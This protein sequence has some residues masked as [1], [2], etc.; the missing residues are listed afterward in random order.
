MNGE[1]SLDD[2]ICN[3]EGLRLY[4]YFTVTFYLNVVGG[5]I[6]HSAPLSDSD[7]RVSYSPAGV[8]LPRPT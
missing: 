2:L 5:W 6:G 8:K 3:V 4:V 1:A 7:R